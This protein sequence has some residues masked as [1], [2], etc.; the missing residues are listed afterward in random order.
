MPVCRDKPD[1]LPSLEE[2]GIIPVA[3]L[4]SGRSPRR[5]R[6]SPLAPSTRRKGEVSVFPDSIHKMLRLHPAV[7]LTLARAIPPTVPNLYFSR[8]TPRFRSKTTES[9]KAPSW[10]PSLLWRISDSKVRKQS[11]RP[12]LVCFRRKQRKTSPGQ[13]SPS[14]C[15]KTSPSV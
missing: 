11:P 4:S 6:S 5:S 15:L 12:L 7:D 10:K 14:M 3:P 8:R 1:A 9:P 13:S 2:V